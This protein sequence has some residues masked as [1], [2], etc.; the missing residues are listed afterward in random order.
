MTIRRNGVTDITAA[1]SST[2]SV[3]DSAICIGRLS[4][5][6]PEG[7][8]VKGEELGVRFARALRATGKGWERDVVRDWRLTPKRRRKAVAV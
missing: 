4:V 3:R 1:G 6:P 5:L 7:I 2:S 8:A